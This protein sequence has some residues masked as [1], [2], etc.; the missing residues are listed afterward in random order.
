M[1][2]KNGLAVKQSMPASLYAIRFGRH[3]KDKKYM[4]ICIYT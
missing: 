3:Y 4:Y 1:S 2:I